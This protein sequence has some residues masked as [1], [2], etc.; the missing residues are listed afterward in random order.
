MLYYQRSGE[1]Y[2]K[3]SEIY[4]RNGDFVRYKDSDNLEEYNRAAYALDERDDL[5]DGKSSLEIQ[6][7][8]RLYHRLGESYILE[9]T[10]MTSDRTPNNPF[11]TGRNGGAAGFA[12]TPSG[13]NLYPGRDFRSLAVGLCQGGACGRHGGGICRNQERGGEG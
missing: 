11:D 10:W 6:T 4:D 12:E 2:D 3:G 8:D 1:T 13:G 7:Q 9:N 5:Y